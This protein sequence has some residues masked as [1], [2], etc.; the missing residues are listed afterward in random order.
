MQTEAVFENIADRIRNE[1][2]QSQ[3]S[4]YIA[5]A[6]FTNKTLFLELLS[7]AKAGCKISLII[8]NDIINDN[9]RIDFE[10][11][12]KYNSKCI[13]ISAEGQL[14]HNKFCVIDYST[15]ITGSYNWSYKA[16]NN[17][18]NIV[19]TND[20]NLAAQFI[21]EFNQIYKQFYPK[22]AKI[23]IEFPL[24]KIIQYLE[25]LKNYILLEDHVEL[26]KIAGKLTEYN[27]NSDINEIISA[28]TLKEYS[29]AIRKIQNFISQNQQ[30][31]IWIDPDIAALQLEIKSLENQLNAFDNERI[32]LVK[33][34]A[35]FQHRH[36]IELGSIILQI[37]KIKKIKFKDNK[38]KYDE[39]ETDEKQYQEQVETERHRKVFELTPE[40]KIE[41][42]KKFRKATTICH[43]D[44]VSDSLKDAAQQIFIELKRAYDSNNLNKVTEILNELELN[45]LFK[46]KSETV[47]EKDILIVAITNLKSQIKKIEEDIISIK[48]NGTFKTITSIND[49]DLYFENVKEKLLK[50]LENLKLEV[51]PAH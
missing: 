26:R 14:M 17:F 44:K 15:V 51:E 43:P 46:S 45:N 28:T 21:S 49:W 23:V 5:V 9:S 30:L 36:T 2:Q 29:T 3:N 50:E 32:E 10:E 37:F 33:M 13:R 7:K 40:E 41:L 20:S 39:T 6:W 35:D 31:T 22:S 47:S 38:A 4:I 19:V 34:I 16:E 8:S 48:E 12:E 18:E 42:K 1:I 25:I 27:F 24:V 11:L